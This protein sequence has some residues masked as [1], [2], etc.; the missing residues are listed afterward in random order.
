MK[1]LFK[2]Y[3]YPIATLSG[4]VIGVGFLSLPYITL[5][6]GIWPML[7]YFTTL[8]ALVVFLHVIFGQISLK[9]PDFKRF[10]GFVGFYL[11]K[12]V[13]GITLILMILG[14]FGVL[15][16][17][18][19]IGGQFLSGI[20]SPLLGGGAFNYTILYFI[21]LSIIIYFGIN[22]IS[23]LEFWAITFLL[24][25]FLI[26]FIKG[27]YYIKIGNIFSNKGLTHVNWKNAFLPYGAIIFSLWGVGLIPEIE[28]MV[29]GRKKLLKRIIVI[30]MLIPAIIYLLFIFL[31]L[32]ISG[33]QTTE[34]AL[35]GLKTFLGQGIISIA[36]F[37]G[38]ITTF[39]AF[40]A[41]GLLLKKVFMYDLGVKEFP[42]WVLTCFPPLIFFL[43]GFNSFIVLIS[44]VG[45]VLLSIDGI[46]ILLMYKKIGGKKIIA[47]PL[48]LVFV[49]GIIYEVIYFIK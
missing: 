23:K 5:K 38:V 6:V 48:I 16:A 28:E 9:T 26:I 12:K 7:F 47:Y 19:V 45:G 14:S 49:L 24:I 22:A 33:N 8:T 25:S 27:F 1:D 36:L 39:T 11:G 37:V 3:I 31:I 40:I 20:L 30:S 32:G 21:I 44:F 2:N 10:P 42:A 35:I 34:S 13:E 15:L 17:Y 46:L 29:R 43:L 41:Q 4:S 18:L